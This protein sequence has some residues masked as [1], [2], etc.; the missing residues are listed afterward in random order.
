MIELDGDGRV[1][2]VSFLSFEENDC[3]FLWYKSS[4]EKQLHNLMT[5]QVQAADLLLRPNLFLLQ[6]RKKQ[7]SDL[8]LFT[9]TV[10]IYSLSIADA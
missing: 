6:H 2:S 1:S 5:A 7:D 3:E 9:G 10:M 8:Q 4:D